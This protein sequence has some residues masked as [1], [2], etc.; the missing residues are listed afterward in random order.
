M[1]FSRFFH[2]ITRNFNILYKINHEKTELFLNFPEYFQNFRFFR[3]FI[4]LSPTNLENQSEL[5]Q[6]RVKTM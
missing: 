4:G 6:I 2:E 3:S 5:A 1:L